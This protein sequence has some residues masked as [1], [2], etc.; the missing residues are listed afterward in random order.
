[1]HN[2]IYG[3]INSEDYKTYISNAGIY[4]SPEKRYRKYAVLGRNGHFLEDTGI[5]ENV[6][7]E[8]PFC[9]YE[10]CD[11]N[12]RSYISA[13]RQKKGY[14]RIEDTF[15]S[16]YYRMGAFIDEFEPKEVAA[17][18]SICNGILKFDCMPQK[19]LKSGEEPIVLYIGAEIV[20]ES[21]EVE[22]QL[23]TSNMDITSATA[24][25]SINNDTINAV[26]VEAVAYSIQGRQF[27]LFDVELDAHERTEESIQF[28]LPISPVDPDGM[29]SWRLIC[30]ADHDTG[31]FDGLDITIETPNGTSYF[32]K[33]FV[34][35]NP[36]G[37]VAK[38]LIEFGGYFAGT[39]KFEILDQ[40]SYVPDQTYE[41]S[42]T[43]SEY[44]QKC[45]LDCDEQ[46]MYDDDGNSLGD[47]IVIVTA[48]DSKGKNLVF[49]ELGSNI[50][51]ISAVANENSQA[52]FVRMMK[53][54]PRWWTV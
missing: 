40:G 24:T 35:N 17:D 7:I 10:N 54:Y 15:H 4:K 27:Q 12:I 23:A 9:T 8:Y 37:F 44:N 38:P 30:Y 42:F 14:Q 34:I 52:S 29:F 51:I 26:R 21:T 49:P 36:T 6:E 25:I 33:S 20:P 2:L 45:W 43:D 16:E 31:V 32:G 39:L 3:G 22:R 50:T 46:W 41:L 19:W 1:M 13:L 28:T 11:T 53:I 48:Q 47:K 18:G 5:F